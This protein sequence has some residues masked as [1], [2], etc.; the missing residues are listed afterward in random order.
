MKYLF[1]I[2]LIH[3]LLFGAQQRI[4]ALSPAINEIL[5]ALGAGDRIVGN[6]LYATYPKEA[7]KIPKV[8][9]YFSVSL[10]KIIA[11]EPTLLLMQRNN[12]SLKPKLEKLGIKV[13]V[14]DLF[15]LKDIENAILKIADMTETRSKAKSIVQDIEAH[16]RSL[17]GILQGKKILIVFGAAEALNRALYVSGNNLYFADIIRASGNQNAFVSDAA[18]QPTLS[19]EGVIKLNPDIVYILAHK[20]EG[21]EREKMIAPWL[22]LPIAAAKAKTVYLTTKK[23]AGMPSQRVIFFMEDF[24]EVLQDASGKLAALHD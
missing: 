8:G 6:T 2:L 11:L 24:K 4:V 15:S 5:F 17:K 21:K 18:K 14:L 22:E 7:E 16:L 3:A 10:E 20:I 1:I 12:L 23:H 9:G 19:Q 13:V